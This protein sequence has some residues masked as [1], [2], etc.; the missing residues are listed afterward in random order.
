MAIKTVKEVETAQ[1]VGEF[2]IGPHAFS[3]QWAP[4]EKDLVKQAPID[5]INQQ[6]HRYWYVETKEG[7]IIGALG[8]RENKYGSD[9]YE[10]DSDYAAVH[11]D[12]RKQGIGSMLLQTM[13]EFVK[14]NGGRY[15]HVPSCDTDYYAPARAFY[16]KLGY[17]QVGTMPNYYME[18]EGRVDFY[19]EL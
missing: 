3:H 1:R 9:G 10:M 4:N 11:K 14:Q 18:G 5:S 8:V 19:K 12:Y 17:T 16:Q 2:L 7:E 13:E 15:V 6:K